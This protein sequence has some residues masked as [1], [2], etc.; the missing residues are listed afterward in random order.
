MACR[1]VIIRGRNM[2]I[3][4]LLSVLSS[5]TGVALIVGLNDR[6]TPRGSRDMADI[7]GHQVGGGV[8][9]VGQG[10]WPGYVMAGGAGRCR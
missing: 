10:C 6:L 4:G 1:T 2:G 3:V 8:V 7:T 9:V 5:M